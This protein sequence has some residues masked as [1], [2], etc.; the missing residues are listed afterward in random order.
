MPR[1]PLQSPR[2]A[3]F[4]VL[5][6]SAGMVYYYVGLFL[7][8]AQQLRIAKNLDGGYSFGNDFYPIWLTTRH[9]LLHLGSPYTPEMTRAI[10]AGL[11]GRPLDARN[12]S[13]P[14]VNC[15]AFAYP[16]YT[17]IV[18]W[19]LAAF[20]FAK[21]RVGLAVALAVLTAASSL[22]WLRA[23]R[24]RASPFFLAVLIIFTLSSYAVMEGL[25]AAQP[26]LLVAFLLSAC[27]AALVKDRFFLAGSLFAFTLIKPQVA[28]LVLLYLLVWS[29]SDWRKRRGFVAGFFACSGLL[30]ATSLIVWPHWMVQWLHVVLTYG[31][32]TPP[33]LITYSMGPKLGPLLTAALLMVALIVMWRLRQ[34]PATSSLFLLNISLLLALT[35]ITLLPGQAV[36]DHIVLL[37]GILFMVTS[38]RRLVSSGKAFAVL[39]AAGVLVL[40]WQWVAV[41]PLLAFRYFSA[42]P[43]GRNLLMLPLDAASFVPLALSAVFA[44]AMATALRRESLE[45]VNLTRPVPNLFQ[46]PVT[47]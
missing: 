13:D 6:V 41:L 32:Y 34:V 10:Q 5:V 38:W 11:F 22:L 40:F 27:F 25:F 42:R 23:L 4:L 24:Y 33:P 30:G 37:P 44:Y 18:F 3:L 21:V 35:S 43:F 46:A 20:S 15:R 26:G 14:P 8:Y 1:F 17:D 45:S 12:P 2:M 16:A 28:A 9:S 29:F 7:P 39:L 47:K 36:Y 19:P 31:N